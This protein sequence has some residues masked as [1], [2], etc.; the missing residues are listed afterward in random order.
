M[1]IQNVQDN[2][3]GSLFVSTWQGEIVKSRITVLL[4]GR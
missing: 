4:D 1:F 2:A 3:K